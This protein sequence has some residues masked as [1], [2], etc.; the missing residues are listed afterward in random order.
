MDDDLH[1]P[2]AQGL[3]LLLHDVQPSRTNRL[4][5]LRNLH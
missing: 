2:K 3:N 4:F 1:D 5:S